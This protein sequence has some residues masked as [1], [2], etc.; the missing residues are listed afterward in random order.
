MKNKAFFLIAIAFLATV[1][2]QLSGQMVSDLKNGT[3]SLIPETLYL[4]KRISGGG[5]ITLLTSSTLNK[6]GVCNFDANIL[7]AGRILVFDQIS[8]GYKSD[9]SENKEGAITYNAIAPK[10]LQNAIFTISQK[11][12]VLFSK[13]FVDLHNVSAGLTVKTEDAYTELKT[14][15]LLVDNTPVVMKLQFPEGVVL[16]DTT[17]KHYVEVRLNGLATSAK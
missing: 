16:D 17:V 12:K 7:Q 11:G 10:E 6:P 2:H 3:L 14:M 4:R 5:E 8:L 1:A 13:P 15:C 9:L